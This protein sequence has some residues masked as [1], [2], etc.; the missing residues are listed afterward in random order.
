MMGVV[1][2][3]PKASSEE[4]ALTSGIRTMIPVLSGPNHGLEAD[5]EGRDTIR[6][7]GS[8]PQKSAAR[9]NGVPDKSGVVKIR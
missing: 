9:A 2:C 3:R 7:I 6:R 5:F 4:D 1:H 8:R